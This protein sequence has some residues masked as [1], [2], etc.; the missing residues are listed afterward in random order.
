VRSQLVQSA[1]VLRGSH[2]RGL[3]RTLAALALLA[4]GVRALVPTGYML[5]PA[6]AGQLVRVTLCTAH[7]PATAFIDLKTGSTKGAEDAPASDDTRNA[8]PCV[9]AATAHLAPPG[10]APAILTPETR[11]EPAPSASRTRGAPG[12]LAPPPW[13]TGPPGSL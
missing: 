1:R 6:P 7:G 8:A 3:A 5:A 13:A 4:M 10:A 12:L 2:L 9:F 11:A